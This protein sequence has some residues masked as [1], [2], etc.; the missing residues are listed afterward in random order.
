MPSIE[1]LLLNELKSGVHIRIKANSRLE[2]GLGRT[3]GSLLGL[4]TGFRFGAAVETRSRA[5]SQV[6]RARAGPRPKASARPSAKGQVPRAKCQGF[7]G[8]V[9]SAKE[10]R[11]QGGSRSFH[12]RFP[13]R[14]PGPFFRKKFPEKS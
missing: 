9:P 8:Q 2:R 5:Q 12:S 3:R 7:R 13:S 1:S 4:D 14:I 10:Q 11:K 6:P